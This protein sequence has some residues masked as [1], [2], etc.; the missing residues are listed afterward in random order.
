MYCGVATMLILILMVGM[1]LQQN[2]LSFRPNQEMLLL[3]EK[4]PRSKESKAKKS[5]TM[6]T[7]RF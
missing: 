7:L 1:S 5:P 3:N 6:K 4:W 2:H